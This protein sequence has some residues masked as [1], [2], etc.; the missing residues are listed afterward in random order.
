MPNI[1]MEKVDYQ[2]KDIPVT[3]RLLGFINLIKIL[4]KQTGYYTKYLDGIL[5]LNKL[6]G[7]FNNRDS[8]LDSLKK[9]D[10]NSILCRS[11]SNYLDKYKQYN[12][13]KSI[14]PKD[15]YIFS[16]KWI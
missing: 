5:E 11:G 4:G 12:V 7:S 14:V 6:L 15:V 10:I 1:N 8:I 2:Y 9:Y 13:I 3:F 16:I